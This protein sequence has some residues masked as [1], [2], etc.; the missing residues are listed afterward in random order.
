MS[1]D[2]AKVAEIRELIIAEAKSTAEKL[3]AEAQQAAAALNERSREQANN[4]V[5]AL[6][7][8]ARESAER[9]RRARL[10]GAASTAGNR[11][12]KARAAV[13]DEALAAATLELQKLRDDPSYPEWLKSLLIE[14]ALALRPHE[15]LDIFLDARDEAIVTNDF[16]GSVE[17]VLTFSHSLGVRFSLAPQRIQTVGGIILQARGSSLR[18]DNTFEERLRAGRPALMRLVAA[19]VLGQ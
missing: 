17:I 4:A 13:F 9:Q 8:L 10:A 12:L 3:V 16:L 18:C 2:N 11:V 15:Q 5:A 7:R 6:T 1:S 14:A 19:Q